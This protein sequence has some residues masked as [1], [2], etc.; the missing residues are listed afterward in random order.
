MKKYVLAFLAVLL[1]VIVSYSQT[2]N[3]NNTRSA[4]KN[5]TAK[6]K[7]AAQPKQSSNTGNSNQVEVYVGYSVTAAPITA[8]GGFAG[9]E[10]NL[11][12]GVQSSVTVNVNR[13]MGIKGDFSVGYR[14]RDEAFGVV[15]RITTV[16]RRTAIYNLLGG[17]QFKDNESDAVLKPFGHALVGV[18]FY[19]QSLRNCQNPAGTFCGTTVRDYGLAGAFGGGLDFRIANRAGIRVSSDYNPMRIQSETVNNYRFGVGVVFK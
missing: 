4:T 11:H 3:Y 6:T 1:S 10:R 5:P 8:G 9:N 7:K 15:G 17:V 12:H 18:G 13:F 16:T 2:N 19:R 14:D